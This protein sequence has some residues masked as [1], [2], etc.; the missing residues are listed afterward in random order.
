ML[1]KMTSGAFQLLS[2]MLLDGLRVE[3]GTIKVS[4]LEARGL[5]NT[6]TVGMMDPYVLLFS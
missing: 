4:V 3:F 6:E 5:Y 1:Q 2:L